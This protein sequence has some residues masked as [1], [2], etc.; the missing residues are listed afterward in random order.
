MISQRNGTNLLYEKMKNKF[1][2]FYVS[3]RMKTEIVNTVVRHIENCLPRIRR[4][5]RRLSPTYS[6]ELICFVFIN[7]LA[8]FI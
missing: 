4:I 2:E 1:D 7:H 3:K 8:S 5:L 6:T